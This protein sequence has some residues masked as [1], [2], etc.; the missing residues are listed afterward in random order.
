MAIDDIF[1]FKIK[2]V[3]SGQPVQQVFHYLLFSATSGQLDMSGAIDALATKWVAP[4]R[5]LLSVEYTLSSLTLQLVAKHNAPLVKARSL[6]QEKF[7]E[8]D[9]QVAGD[10][11]P[12][13]CCVYTKLYGVSSN[14]L[15]LRGAKYWGGIP[16]AHQAGGLMGN[17]PLNSWMTFLTTCITDVSVPGGDGGTLRPVVWSRKRYKLNQIPYLCVINNFTPEASVKTQ[18]RRTLATPTGA[19]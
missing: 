16:E 13:Q 10:S 1:E 14:D 11:L 5:A 17:V 18:R 2:G 19:I 15:Y 3:A 12:P 9:G 7:I 4:L 6:L 8:L